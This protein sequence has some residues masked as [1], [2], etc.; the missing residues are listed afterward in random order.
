MKQSINSARRDFLKKSSVSAGFGL[1]VS[2]LGFPALV[3]ADNSSPA[4]LSPNVFV[5]FDSDGTLIVTCHR[6]EMGQQIRTAI[7]QIVADELDADWSRVSV[8]QAKGDPKYGSQ[9]TDGSRSV[10]RNFDR[11][12]EAGATAALMLK[13]AAA[14]G[15]NVSVDDCI[16]KDHG[17]VHTVSN[18]RVDFAELLGVAATLPVPDADTLTLKPRSRW[19][20]IGKGTQSVDMHKVVSGNTTFGQ[21]V[22]L[23]GMLVA[24]IQRPPV[25]FTTPDSVDESAAR[26]VSGVVDVIRMPDASAPAMFNPLGGVAVVAN[27]TWA[28]MQGTKAL[29]ITWTSNE[30]SSYDSESYKASLITTAE[31]PGETVRTR[32]QAEKVIREADNVISA[33]YYAP[34]LSQ[35]PMEPPAATARIDGDNVEVWACT[36]TPQSTRQNV[37]AALKVP[38]ENVTVHVTLLGGGF[39]RKSKPDFSVEAAILA[40]KTGKP[41]KV[42]W[43]REDDI[44]HGYYHSVSAQHIQAVQSESGKT[45]AWRHNTVF[46]TI[47]STFSDKANKPSNG[48]LRLGFIDNPFD[49]EHMLLERGEAQN[50]VRIGWLRSVANVYHAFAIHSFADELAHAAGQDSRDYLLSLIGESRHIDLAKE[51]AEYDN[52]G[53]PLDKYPIDTARLKNVINRVTDMADWDARKKQKRMLGLAA[54]RSFLSYAAIVVEVVVNDSGEWHIPNA[55][56]SL[57]AGTVVNPEHV[58]AQCE[59]GMIYGLSCAIGEITAS[60]GAINQTNFHNYQVARIQHAPHN[61]E[62]DIVDSEAPP[63]GVGEPPTPPFAPALANALFA[64]TGKRLRSLPIPLTLPSEQA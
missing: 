57:D 28:A 23:D 1:S 29:N 47:S 21:D 35:A 46:P 52:Y 31:K 12:R 2:L 54:H 53:D 36:Q 64:A 20:Y 8:T 9:N 6:S 56:I 59:G 37:A 39:G 40:Q 5:E 55:Y 48:E 25:M 11:L 61:I 19:K 58:R 42:V 30:H 15:W 33:T 3:A 14:R 34:L 49:I 17:V 43:R 45:L 27:N 50:H 51:G 63:A 18:N 4:G 44:Q 41:V 32:G 26:K 13:Q 16:C 22:Q 62:V 7:A 10:R 38:E 24:I 60:E